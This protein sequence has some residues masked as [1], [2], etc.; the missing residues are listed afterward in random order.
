MAHRL[1]S[2][3]LA[4]AVASAAACGRKPERPEAASA[5]ARDS[6]S[7][8]TLRPRLDATPPYV[9]AD[10]GAGERHWKTV[11]AFYEA[12]G[13]KPVWVLDGKPTS[14][15][16][17]LL[18]S[19]RKAEAEGLRLAEYDLPDPGQVAKAASWNPLKSG[20]DDDAAADL[21]LR[22]SYAFVKYASHLASGRTDPKSVD[23][24]W[25]VTPR[26]VD[27]AAV[28]KQALD[29]GKPEDTLRS[30][31]PQHPQYER[32]R[33][34]LARYR[35][36]AARGGWQALPDGLRLKPGA[37]GPQVALL[38]ARLAATGD[39]AEAAPAA[40]PAA[41]AGAPAGVYD[42]SVRAAVKHFEQ[43]HGL[44]ADGLLDRET[45][46]EMNVPVEARIQQLTLNMERWRW[47]PESL[48]ERHILVN[49][50]TYQLDVYENGQVVLPMRVVA[51]KKDNP[52][53]IFMDKME[54]VVFSPFWN[55]PPNIAR[56]ETIPAAMRDPGYLSRNDMELVKGGR[57]VNPWSVGWSAVAAGDYTFRQRPGRKNALGHVKF[58]FP[59]QFD[60]YLHDTPADNLFART[61]RGFSHGCVRVEKPEEL[62]QYVLRG[63][64]EWTP[65]RIQ[66]A[67]HAGTEKWV[68]LKEPLPVYILYMTAWVDPDGTI[69]FREDIY[70][71][72]EKQQKLL[73]LLSPAPTPVA[74]VKPPTA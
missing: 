32:L 5:G 65:E 23:G 35:D 17:A 44:N 38:R 18:A 28:L 33:E 58:L 12:N 22:L 16:Q 47:L 29:S 74:A 7:E 14:Q 48:G 61:E 30:L 66:A 67:M 72:D 9:A 64:P 45:V 57:V 19:V 25:F 39:L 21:E 51:G 40:T 73:P 62:A 68:A 63:Q 34:T 15:A 56:N 37:R 71:H 3:T 6:K 60:V 41:S 43:R 10:D 55:V 59:N 54:N 42:E 8:G 11:R 20:M 4:A 27:A 70:G 31:A 2:L 50:P 13:F 26:K 49:V 69:Q 53:P 52:T 36:I 1:L 24:H 46:R